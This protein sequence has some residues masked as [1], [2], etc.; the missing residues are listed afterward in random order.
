MSG[1]TNYFNTA[2]NNLT[3]ISFAALGNQVKFV[4]ILI[5]YQQSLTQLASTITPKE[6]VEL[7]TFWKGLEFIG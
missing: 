6:K 7:Y 5:Y 2:G 3:H 4:D 1:K